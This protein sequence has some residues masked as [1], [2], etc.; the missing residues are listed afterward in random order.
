[1]ILS[2]QPNVRWQKL[3]IV[4]SN[5]Q[6][7]YAMPTFT[8]VVVRGVNCG[9]THFQVATIKGTNF[10]GKTRYCLKLAQML[11]QLAWPRE[12]IL[13]VVEMLREHPTELLKYEVYQQ[14]AHRKQLSHSSFL[15]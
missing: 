9:K 7:D 8:V 1:M 5:P 14:A 10:L 3:V 4:V 12:P 2:G 11:G 15:R 13:Q 6:Q